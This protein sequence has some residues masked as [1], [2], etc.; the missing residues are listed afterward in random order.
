MLHAHLLVRMAPDHV[1]AAAELGVCAGDGH[2]HG[3]TSHPALPFH[4]AETKRLAVEQS[5]ASLKRIREQRWG[6]AA[7]CGEVA[8][9][10][11]GFDR[12][13]LRLHCGRQ[14]SLVGRAA[15]VWPKRRPGRVGLG[16]S[17]GGVGHLTGASVLV[18]AG[19]DWYEIALG[20]AD[21]R[22]HHGAHRSLHAP[23]LGL[24]A[25]EPQVHD[26]GRVGHGGLRG[27]RLHDGR[28]PALLLL[29]DHVHRRR[30][31][32]PRCPWARHAVS[33]RAR[34]ADEAVLRKGRRMSIRRAHTR[35]T[36]RN[37]RAPSGGWGQ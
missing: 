22:Q 24:P 16:H 13:H 32:P 8:G 34:W 6:A 31:A 17:P 2:H 30:P 26:G 37:S 7:T 25:V 3:R 9:V 28:S 33:G 5:A 20:G 12:V 11:A 36:E 29:S 18:L 23:L 4:A 27:G 19:R 15:N 21:P 35:Q 1:R 10:R 14:G